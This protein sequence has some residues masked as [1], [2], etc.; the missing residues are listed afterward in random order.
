MLA[1]HKGQPGLIKLE[2]VPIAGGFLPG[3]VIE[4]LLDTP[5]EPSHTPSPVFFLTPPSQQA[6]LAA[7]TMVLAVTPSMP[8]SGIML[9]MPGTVLGV[10][11]ISAPVAATAALP[12]LLAALGLTMLQKDP[13]VVSPLPTTCAPP[14]FAARALDLAL[15]SISNAPAMRTSHLTNLDLALQAGSVQGDLPTHS[16][17]H[18]SLTAEL[19]WFTD[20]QPGPGIAGWLSTGRPPHTFVIL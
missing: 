16:L 13:K 1:E 7:A 11:P 3:E 15:G 8:D 18:D 6:P 17:S 10:T 4:V 14:S 5:S 9:S 2:W 19:V 20:D 12:P